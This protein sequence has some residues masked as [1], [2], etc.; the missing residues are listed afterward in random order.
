MD[1]LRTARFLLRPFC[2]DDKRNFEF[3]SSEDWRK[4]LFHS[5]PDRV[6]F[7]NNCMS[8]KDGFD[9]AII[10]D[11]EQIIGSVH[12]GLGAPSYVGE[13]ACMIDPQFWGEG[14]AFEVCEGLLQH[15]FTST[16]L[17]KAIAHCD[18]RNTGSWKVLEKLGMTR[19]GTLRS[20]RL[21]M[22]GELA[23]EY[24]YGLLKNE[25]RSA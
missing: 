8:S 15:A 12:L 21:T 3:A 1:T 5:F 23:D 13:L 9:L 16:K 11:N 2:E 14:I 7:V 24:C 22:D 18:S 17:H 20:H 4:Y 19:E 6:E 25:W 10:K